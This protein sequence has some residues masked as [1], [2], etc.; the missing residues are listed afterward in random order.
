VLDVDGDGATEALTDGAL[1]A[2]W[3]FG[4]RGAPLIE[5]AV[6]TAHCSRCTAAAIEGYLTAVGEQLDVDGDGERE[7]LT[8][9]VLTV[10]WLFGFRGAAL[11]S[12]AVDGGDCTRCTAEEIEPYLAGM[13]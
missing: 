3:L 2:R 1:V 13:V 8:D 6:D 9:G 7:P 4:F 5:G 10:R 11:V 12:G